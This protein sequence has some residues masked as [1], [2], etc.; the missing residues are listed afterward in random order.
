MVG[1]PLRAYITRFNAATLEVHELDKAVAMS[2]LKGG[3][4]PFWFLFS[5]EKRFL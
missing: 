5:L 4:Q 3:L 2:A 1:E